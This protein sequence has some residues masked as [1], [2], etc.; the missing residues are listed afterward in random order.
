[1]SEGAFLVRDKVKSLFTI[2]ENEMDS[3]GYKFY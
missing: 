3:T 2:S 1:M